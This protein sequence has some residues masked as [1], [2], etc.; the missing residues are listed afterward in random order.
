M[1]AKPDIGALGSPGVVGIAGT[2]ACCLDR[3]LPEARQRAAMA[4]RPSAWPGAEETAWPSRGLARLGRGA[5]GPAGRDGGPAQEGKGRPGR[6]PG[7]GAKPGRRGPAG[8]GRHRPTRAQGRRRSGLAGGWLPR[9]ARGPTRG[10]G[11]L[12]RE[13]PGVAAT[14]PGGGSRRPSRGWAWPGVATFGPRLGLALREQAEY[15]Q[16]QPKLQ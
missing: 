8:D 5:R 15:G 4:W 10:R 11:G 13:Q 1:E 9:P 2:S 12:A 7:E 16:G 14:W 6:K 3:S